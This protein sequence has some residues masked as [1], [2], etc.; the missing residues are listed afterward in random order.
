MS[1][2]DEMCKTDYRTCIAGPGEQLSVKPGDI[3]VGLEIRGSA[4]KFEG[5]PCG[6][7][8]L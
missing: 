4:S 6:V 3:E 1:R 7:L 2:K 8:G 5:N